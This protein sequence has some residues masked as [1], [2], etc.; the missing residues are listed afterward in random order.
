[1]LA[2]DVHFRS[3][4]PACEQVVAAVRKAIAAG[5]MLP[6]DPFPSVRALS[7]ELRINPNAARRI[8]ASLVKQG[9]LEARPGIGTVVS[10]ARASTAKERAQLLED[11]VE[12]I[13]REARKLSLSEQDVMDAVHDLWGRLAKE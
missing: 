10:K 8:T 7:Q 4:I 12:R 2:F 6:G 9:S 3:G 11:D 13:V 1:M 5:Q